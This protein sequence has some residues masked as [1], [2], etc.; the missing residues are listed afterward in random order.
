MELFDP[1][2]GHEGG[3][4]ALRFGTAGTLGDT[5]HLDVSGRKQF[6]NALIKAQVA[7]GM[8]NF[9]VFNPPNAVAGQSRKQSRSRIDAADVPEAAHEQAAWRGFDHFLNAG[10]GS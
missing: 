8:L 7:Y 1:D 9:A 5:N 10:A 4:A 2:G 6:E 3:A